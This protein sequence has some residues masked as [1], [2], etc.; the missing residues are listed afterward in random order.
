MIVTFTATEN[1]NGT[2]ILTFTVNDN[3]GREVVS[4]SIVVIVS[5]ENDPPF[6]TNEIEALVV[7]EDFDENIVINLNEHFD[8][9]E[10][11]ELTYSAVIDNEIVYVEIID[12]ILIIIAIDNLFGIINITIAADDNL[13]SEILPL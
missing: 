11:D 4:D 1:W 2:E 9:P 12:N 6:V 5:Q 3:Q 8:D 7:D 10:G 13:E